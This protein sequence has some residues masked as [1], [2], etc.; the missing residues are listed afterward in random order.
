MKTVF[1]SLLVLIGTQ[2]FAQ[3]T[4][5]K[6]KKGFELQVNS[7]IAHFRSQQSL[8][9]DLIGLDGNPFEYQEGGEF[10][11]VGINA[12]LEVGY[13]FNERWGAGI[14]GGFGVIYRDI[15]FIIPQ[16]RVT[17]DVGVYTTYNFTNRFALTG[18]FGT[19]I[20]PIGSLRRSTASF[21][22]SPEYAL[23]KN[24][25]TKLRLGVEFY[26][27]ERQAS[28]RHQESEWDYTTQTGTNKY[29]EGTA[30]QQTFGW[31]LEAGL[32]FV[33]GD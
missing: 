13:R 32:A 9:V 2:V 19:R 18:T 28:Y 3:E 33:I 29:Y 26:Y 11:S 20:P 27:A 15:F 31:V 10:N 4:S 17:A 22:L 7:S 24:K 25:K 16:F 14:C 1:A 5:T 12:D 6:L 21:G 30:P 8:T 23:G